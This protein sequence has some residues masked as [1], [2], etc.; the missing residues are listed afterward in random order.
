METPVTFFFLL[1]LYLML[2]Y[3]ENN[4]NTLLF[5][6]MALGF[7]IATKA[8]FVF[9]IPAVIFFA[10]YRMHQKTMVTASV[11]IEFV[12]FL[13]LL[14]LSVYLFSY[15]KWF[16]RGYTASEFLQFRL[17]AFSGFD[18]NLKFTYEQ[19]LAFGGKPWEWFIKP[20]ALGHQVFSDGVTGQFIIE[21]NNPVFRMMVLPAL[22]FVIIYAVR[23]RNFHALLPPVVFVLC[24]I[25]FF[26]VKRPMYSYS[27]LVLLPFAYLFLADAVERIAVRY[28]FE[29]TVVTALLCMAFV[30]ECY[31]Y[32]LTTGFTVPVDFYRPLLAI[33]HLTRVF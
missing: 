17:D 31:L 5:A 12:I 3:S 25:L 6:G 4:R 29:K 20:I 18:Q 19:I 21:F 14:P 10:L 7:T 13:M 22:V 30:M 8:Y 32:P 27:A 16:G 33:T 28:Q 15:V 23:K 1:F 9:A 24:Y 26:L 2:E 11:V